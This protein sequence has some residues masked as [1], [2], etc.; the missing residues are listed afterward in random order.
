MGP[1]KDSKKGQIALLMGMM[2]L[3][4]IMLFAFVVNTGVLVNAKISLQ[5]AADLAAYS[6]AATQA[7]QLNIISFLN[8]EMRRQYKKFIFR[9]YV[10]GNM[11]QDNFPTA[12]S[13][14]PSSKRGDAYNVP[15]VCITFNAKDNYCHLDKLPAVKIPKDYGL[16][17][18][19]AT[20]RAQSQA[21]EELRQASCISIGRLNYLVLSTW[22]FNTDPELNQMAASFASSGDTELINHLKVIKGLAYGLGVVP[23]EVILGLRVVNMLKMVNVAPMGDIVYSKIGALKEDAN[24]LRYERTINAF[25]SAYYSLSKETFPDDSFTMDELLPPS[26]DESNFLELK[27]INTT[28][29][30][31]SVGFSMGGEY[32]ST[33]KDPNECLPAGHLIKVT[34]MPVGFYKTSTN[35]VYYAVRLRAKPLLLFS[36]FQYIELTAYAA[37]KP[38]GSRIG[39]A[40]GAN[41]FTTAASPGGGLPPVTGGEGP[42]GKIPSLPINGGDSWNDSGKLS[43]FYG[44]G[45]S[46]GNVIDYGAMEKGLLAA[47]SPTVYE[48]GRYNMLLRGT[49]EQDDYFTQ[50][51]D[52]NFVARLYAPVSAPEDASRG[53]ISDGIAKLM[54]ISGT[55]NVSGIQGTI[56]SGLQAG[57]DA[58]TARLQNGSGEQEAPNT[59]N[60]AG[61]A[62]GYNV[63]PL[64]DPFWGSKGLG[65]FF[66]EPTNSSS[67]TSFVTMNS[68]DYFGRGRNGYSVKFISMKHLMRLPNAPQM[69]GSDSDIVELM[70]H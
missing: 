56:L 43:V 5:N 41:D 49:S 7:R 66:L 8:Y 52:K 40:L 12:P 11:A 35:Q 51:E 28:F 18:I 33:S 46:S 21:I 10:Y 39:P 54:N 31:W 30:T 15:A 24:A 62:E 14:K 6:G 67:H 65:G 27:T 17:M 50:Y 45:T 36:P 23:R 42:S 57:V 68:T 58:Y 63:V 47:T 48:Q 26:P 25:L 16:D 69:P 22:L 55:G 9:Y 44:A 61:Y 53:F 20:L 70:M 4:F 64:L 59:S 38:F 34:D 13:W 3:T 60:F 37:A 29:D 1:G 2:T 32:T 19:N